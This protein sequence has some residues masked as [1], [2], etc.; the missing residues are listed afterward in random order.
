VPELLHYYVAYERNAFDWMIHDPVFS[1]RILGVNLLIFLFGMGLALGISNAVVGAL[2]LA[3]ATLACRLRQWP[4][5]TAPMV[6]LYVLAICAHPFPLLRY[7]APLAP[8]VYAACAT[9]V[10]SLADAIQRLIGRRGALAGAACAAVVIL[11]L[12]YEHSVGVARYVRLPPELLHVELGLPSAVRLPPFV[13]TV[14]WLRAHASANDRIA[15]RHD[16]YYFLY[17]GLQGVRPW[18]PRP[19]TY[20]QLYGL[21]PGEPLSSDVV[22]ADLDRLGVTLVIVDQGLGGGENVFVSR[23]LNALLDG[24]SNKWRLVFQTSDGLHRVYR[25]AW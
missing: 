25:K 5:V 22:N 24:P 18:I 1:A 3:S 7:L 13:E 9:G 11:P 21:Q 15:A 19:E 4:A 2:V 14:N 20:L 10:G 16:P 12:S 8:L 17:T 23:Q 6:S